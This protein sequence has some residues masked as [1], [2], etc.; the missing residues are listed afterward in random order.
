MTDE[1]KDKVVLITGSGR[2]IGR[3][4]ALSM[5]ESGAQVVVNAR[6]ASDVGQ[7]VAEIR[8]KNG[9]AL[10]H[11]ADVSVPDQVEA[12]VRR[13]SRTFGPVD[14][15]VNCAGIIGPQ[16]FGQEVTP[17]EF[18]D[19]LKVNL[20]GTFLCCKYVLP[21]MIQR[22]SG[23]IINFTGGGAAQPLKGGLPYATSKAGIEGLTRNLA[24]EVEPM[25]ITCNCISPGRV[26]TPGFP[27]GPSPADQRGVV[28]PEHAAHLAVWLASD[29]SKDVNG[30]AI[31]APA[32]DKAR[33]R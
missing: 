15:L 23:R 24:L 28:G 1:L 18:L 14:V 17:G 7:V 12:M 9:A 16:A 22:R 11:A 33:A 27:V 5:A 25:G 20:W 4:I 2:G 32:W 21:A 31:D 19:V 13:V 6:S 10:P 8:A 3:A 29:A 30:Q 26:D